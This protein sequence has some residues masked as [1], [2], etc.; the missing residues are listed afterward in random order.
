MLLVI[1][2]DERARTM[3]PRLSNASIGALEAATRAHARQGVQGR[4]RG[5]PQLYEALAESHL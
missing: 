4:L 2:V 3:R 1:K 5:P